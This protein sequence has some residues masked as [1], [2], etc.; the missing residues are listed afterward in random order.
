M[1]KSFST[2]LDLTRFIAAAA[3]VLAH[4]IQHGFINI[5]TAHYIP[6]LGREAVMVFFVLSGYVIAYTTDSKKLSPKNYAIARASRIYSVAL[7]SLLLGFIAVYIYNA[8]NPTA[9]YYQ[10]DKFYIYIPFHSLFLGELWTLTERPPWLTPYWSLS[11][12]VW[13]YILF[14]CFFFTRKMTR[15]ILTS[16]VLLIM[17]YK[18]WL[19]LPV[20]LSG[21]LL[22]RMQNC[23]KVSPL[24]ASYCWLGSFILLCLFK[25]Y[26]FDIGLRN[27]GNAIWPFDNYALGSAD[28]FL[29]DYL[30]CVIVLINFFFAY[31][32]SFERLV[33]HQK[34]IQ[35]IAAYTFTL[36]LTH[37]IVL[38]LWKRLF[39]HNQDN[40]LHIG[41]LVFCIGLTTYII[42]LFTEQKRYLFT[43][44]I[45]YLI[46]FTYR[47]FN[48]SVFNTR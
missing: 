35:K 3:V 21:V 26:D 25:F 19:L 31:H 16:I 7:P 1:H 12:E 17:G 20:W 27:F 2:Y 42:G 41:L 45:E 13:Y 48:K 34:V 9:V 44:V 14:G 38:E 40:P 22:F 24:V 23:V 18:L 47:L 32:M 37:F 28:R 11:Y 15:F 10:L 29:S 43:R 4:L 36:Y 6:D 33:I 39:T 8:F 30:V 5:S 46:S